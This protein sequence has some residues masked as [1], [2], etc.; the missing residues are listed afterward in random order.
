MRPKKVILLVDDNEVQISLRRF[1]LLNS[2]YR[3]LSAGNGDEALTVLTQAME[4]RITVDVLVTDL[5]MPGM[6][7]N[8]LIRKVKLIDPDIQAIL[9]SASVKAMRTSHYAEDFLPKGILNP[10]EVLARIKI[11][12]ARKRG[13]KQ[14]KNRKQALPVDLAVAGVA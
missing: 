7:G 4:K 5:V 2:G 1:L 3:V 8:E 10:V 9:Y 6:D 13:P 12:A 11:H 14:I